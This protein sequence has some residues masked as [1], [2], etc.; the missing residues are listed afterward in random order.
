MKCHR[1]HLKVMTCVAVAAMT[2]FVSIAARAQQ[3]SPSDAAVVALARQQQT[4]VMKGDVTAAQATL[5]TDA[6]MD[7][8]PRRRNFRAGIRR[9]TT[10]RCPISAACS[11]PMPAST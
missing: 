2:A 5:D 7:R 1:V 3:A 9:I 8:V 6:L 11:P 4:A 10:P